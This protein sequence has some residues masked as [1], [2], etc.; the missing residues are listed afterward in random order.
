M[1]NRAAEP[2]A[3]S[4]AQIS[5]TVPP[6]IA[7]LAEP[8]KPAIKRHTRRVAKLFAAPDAAMKAR[9]TVRVPM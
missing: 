7:R 1:K 9:N 5:A 6:P 8:A 2:P 3:F 4:R